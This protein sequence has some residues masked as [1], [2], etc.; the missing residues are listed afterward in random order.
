MTIRVIIIHTKGE[1]EV[2]PE[3]PGTGILGRKMW[4]GTLH[5]LH[6]SNIRAETEAE[7]GMHLLEERLRV[8]TLWQTGWIKIQE[9]KY[10]IIVHFVLDAA[11][12]TTVGTTA[13]CTRLLNHHFF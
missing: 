10:F 3:S 12:L 5:H 1:E 6:H 4:P 13:P 7:V 11:H 2:F 8:D 9:M